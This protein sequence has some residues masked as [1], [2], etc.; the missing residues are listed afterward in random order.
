MGFDFYCSVLGFL[1]FRHPTG[2][3]CNF[4]GCNGI[5]FFCKE[6]IIVQLLFIPHILD[7]WQTLQ[8][9]GIFP[10]Y[11]MCHGIWPFCTAG[12]GRA[13]L[14]DLGTRSSVRNMGYGSPLK[15]TPVT[16]VQI[17]LYHNTSKLTCNKKV[18]LRSRKRRT[19][20][21]ISCL[22]Q[23]AVSRGGT[24]VLVLAG[25][26][27]PLSWSWPWGGGT[28]V[29]GPDWCIPPPNRSW[30]RTT[31]LPPRKDLGPETRGNIS[32]E[33][34]YDQRPGVPRFPLLPDTHLWIQ[35]LHIILH[36][37]C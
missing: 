32:W 36:M 22:W 16:C 14:L 17:Q 5:M 26:G 29:L 15:I 11:H 34:T 20:C 37:R 13:S 2:V 1:H 23:C 3:S 6:N 24:P 33:R 8:T 27:V 35:Y 30:D 31:P 7:S 9:G 18:P 28:P 25:G 21:D 4:I 12:D 19:T 10:Y